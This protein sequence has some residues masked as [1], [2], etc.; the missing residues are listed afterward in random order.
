MARRRNKGITK[1]QK[2]M[3][4][5]YTAS[6]HTNGIAYIDVAQSLSMCNRKLF[7]QEKV[8]GIE[9]I[10]FSFLPTYSE[11]TPGSGIFESDYDILQVWIRT[12]GDTWSVH[13]AW[14]KGQA[15][16]SEMQDLVLADNPS[17]KGT[18]S[19]FKVFLDGD[20]RN[21]VKGAGAPGNLL[22]INGPGFVHEGE[23]DYT[24]FVLPQH[25]VDAAGVPLPAD[26]TFVHLVGA[27]VGT[28]GAFLSAGLVEAYSQSRSTVQNEDPSVPAGMSTSFFNLLTDSGSQEPELADVIETEN[29]RPPYDQDEYPGGKLNAPAPWFESISTANVGHPNGVTPGFLAQCGLIEIRVTGFKDGFG[30]TPTNQVNLF[31]TVAPGMYKG[32]AAIDMGQ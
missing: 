31:L 13:N 28:H 6:E 17:I 29:D 4:Y 8:Y 5:S 23:W 24:R 27:D 18:W 16:H 21:A 3:V 1:A 11:T 14:V 7:S 9:K 12:A 30:V 22:P 20:H 15:L 32:V 19:D 10:D 2:T 26:E 25:E